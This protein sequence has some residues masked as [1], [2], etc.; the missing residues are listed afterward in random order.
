MPTLA[1]CSFVRGWLS[2]ACRRTDRQLDRVGQPAAN[3]LA[4]NDPIDNRL[5]GGSVG[6]PARGF[7]TSTTCH[8]PL[9]DQNQP[10][11]RPNTSLC[12]PRGRDQAPSASPA[13]HR[14]ARSRESIPGLLASAARTGAY[15]VAE[16]GEEQPQVIV[17]SVTVATVL[18]GLHPRPVDRNR[19]LEPS[20]RS[21][22][23]SI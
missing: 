18:R 1:P 7:S 22:S 23:G 4:D 15:R 20:I 12:W 17:D 16:P 19:R 8:R 2:Q 5:E 9:P 3:V 11:D 6:G 21:T 13:S 10:C 14:P